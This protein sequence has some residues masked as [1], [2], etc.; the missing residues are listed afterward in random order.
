MSM[1]RA[2][3]FSLGG[4]AAVLVLGYV[5]LPLLREPPPLLDAPMVVEVVTIAEETNVPPPAPPEPE[6]KPEQAAAPPE[7]EPA[8]KPPPPPPPVEPPPVAAPTPEPPSPPQPATPSEPKVAA[9][10][11]PAEPKPQAK[12]KPA[13]EPEAKPKPRPS[14]VLVKAKPKRKPKKPDMFASVLKTVEDLKKQAPP[15]A[16]KPEKPKP[17]AGEDFSQQIARALSNQPVSHDPTR[18]LTMSEIDAVR[19][20][21]AQCWNVPAGAKDAE[22]LVI[23]IGMQMNPDGS[24]RRAEIQDQTRL[25]QDQFFRAAAESALRAVLNPR[26]NPLRLPRDK[27]DRWKTMTLTF[28]PKQMFGAL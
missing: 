16:E 6:P 18:P 3:A 4:H 23:A 2:V 11:P 1:H 7:P 15:P 20:Q 25:R 22:D 14:Q 21:I 24:V 13:P 26:C 19:H 27:Y 8:P 9:L 17:D 10:P 28:N 5:G 12:P